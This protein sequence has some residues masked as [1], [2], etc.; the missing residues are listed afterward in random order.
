[1]YISS[2]IERINETRK[3]FVDLV[4]DGNC[5]VGKIVIGPQLAK[6]HFK[7][8]VPSEF[9]GLPLEVDGKCIGQVVKL[10]IEPWLAE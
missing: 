5:R 8:E 9:D 3:R 6:Q 4:V 1:M 7:G 2:K 10:V